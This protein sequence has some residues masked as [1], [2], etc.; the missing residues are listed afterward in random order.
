MKSGL[1]RQI[2][3]ALLGEAVD[4]LMRFQEEDSAK[5]RKAFDLWRERSP[6][7]AAAW[8]RAESL[9]DT[10]RQVPPGLG[11]LTLGRA[12]RIGRR[13]VLR[14]LAVLGVT[15][16]LGWLLT[17]Q[18]RLAL[19]S[20]FRTATAERRNLSLPDGAR[21]VLNAR[22]AVRSSAGTDLQRLDLLQ[23]E[24][25]LTTQAHQGLAAR[26]FIQ[27]ATPHGRVETLSARL[28]VRTDPVSSQV[29]VFEGAARIITSRGDLLEL[30]AGKQTY[31]DHALIA[32]PIA[33]E[34]DAAD[35]ERGLLVAREMS[36]REVLSRLA[37][38]RHG[39][40][41]CNDAVANLPVSGVFSLDDTDGSLDLLVRTLPVRLA[42]FSRWWVSLEPVG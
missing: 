33:L 10:V 9:I 24:V 1:S 25:L 11:H 23:G 8:V 26:S 13:R 12:N 4:W 27:L 18:A 32:P 5:L 31:F 38:Y 14:C 40:I 3:P 6:E 22:S 19:Q 29:S 37:P 28:S 15:T 16:P 2:D 30:N 35:W 17:E 34:A 20:D 36:L 41:G 42:S 39:R 21:L 7:H